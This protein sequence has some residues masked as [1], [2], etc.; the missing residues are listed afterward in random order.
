M[1]KE[2]EQKEREDA[3]A[4]NDNAEN[5]ENAENDLN[6]ISKSMDV[7]IL[8][9]SDVVFD[10]SLNKRIRMS[11]NY[12][13]YPFDEYEEDET[14]MTEYGLKVDLNEWRAEPTKS[15]KKK[16]MNDEADEFEIL[17]R[18]LSPSLMILL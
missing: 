5:D 6:K 7:D 1:G 18:S 2:K 4:F 10:A 15:P 3:I 17:A 13:M 12:E 11:S 16:N 8:D 9:S 14:I